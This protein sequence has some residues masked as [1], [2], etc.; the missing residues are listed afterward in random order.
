MHEMIV[1]IFPSASDLIIRQPIGA[2][3]PHNLLYV[4]KYFLIFQRSTTSVAFYGNATPTRSPLQI[5]LFEKSAPE[6]RLLYYSLCQL[7]NKYS[8]VSSEPVV[9]KNQN[10]TRAFFFI[11]ARKLWPFF[12]VRQSHR[13]ACKLLQPFFFG[14][15]RQRDLAN[16]YLVFCCLFYDHLSNKFNDCIT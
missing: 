1:A 16:D 11:Q 3:R 9:I 13:L 10:K 8:T 7:K 15:I 6:S 2:Y 4:C 12:W 5:L 14:P